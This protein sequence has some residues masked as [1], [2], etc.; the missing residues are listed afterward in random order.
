[1]ALPCHLLHMGT[2][3]CSEECFKC[4]NPQ[5]DLKFGEK[6]YIAEEHIIYH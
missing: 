1:M 6:I 3:V 4:S 2:L 5:P